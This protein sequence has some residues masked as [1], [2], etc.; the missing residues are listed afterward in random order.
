MVRQ[1]SSEQQPQAAAELSLGQPHSWKPGWGRQRSTHPQRWVSINSEHLYFCPSDE[2]QFISKCCV[3]AQGVE[4]SAQPSQVG[5]GWALRGSSPCPPMDRVSP[6]MGDMWA[7]SKESLQWWEGDFSPPSSALLLAGKCAF[8]AQLTKE[9]QEN[10]MQIRGEI[11]FR[12][13][14]FVSMTQLFRGKTA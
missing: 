1:L 13:V 3:A 11:N 7:A 14:S 12:R 10:K 6:A 8:K 9:E 5:S 4:L 2:A